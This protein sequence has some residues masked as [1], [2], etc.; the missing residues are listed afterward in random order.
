MLAVVSGC[1]F[2]QISVACM[3]FSNRLSGELLLACVGAGVL[4][5]VGSWAVVSLL[6]VVASFT[7]FTLVVAFGA[8][9]LA[10]VEGLGDADT[11]VALL[12]GA[13]EVDEGGAVVSVDTALPNSFAGATAGV[14]ATATGVSVFF[15]SGMMI[16][17][18]DDVSFS[19]EIGDGVLAAFTSDALTLWVLDALCA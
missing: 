9:A 17:G 4:A 15:G 2:I 12:T 8:V 16:S 14:G 6:M 1:C 5:A 7:A 13:A 3:R 11:V 10:S 18:P 19:F